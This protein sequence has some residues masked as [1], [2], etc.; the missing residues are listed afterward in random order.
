MLN[1]SINLIISLS[2]ILFIL[3]LEGKNVHLRTVKEADLSELYNYFDSIRLKGEYLPGGLLSEY[4]LRREFFETGFWEEEKGMALI[5]QK[6]GRVLGAVWFDKMKIFD[7]YELHFYIFPKEERGKGFMTEA[8]ALFCPYL[9]AT[10]KIERLQISVPDYSKSALRVAQKSGFQ[11]EGI[12]RSA[13]F[14]RGNYLD[15]CVYSLLRAECAK[16]IE[17][18][19]TDN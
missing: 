5:E 16:G 15:L 2:V 11:F 1:F 6:K 7:G 12:A 13:F 17:K 8:L 9:F 14:H 10:K 19:Y 4:Q 18:I 3:M